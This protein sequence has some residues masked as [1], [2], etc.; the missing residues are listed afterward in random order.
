MC[1]VAAIPVALQWIMAGVTVASGVMAAD[2]QRQEGKIEAAVAE[3]NQRIAV[4]QADESNALA[5]R[6]MEQAAWR[7]RAMMGQQRAAFAA[8]NVDPT[9]GTPADIL[10][11]TAMFGEVDQQNVRLNAA[12]QAWGY[13]SDALN[14]GN[15]ASFARWKGNTQS[16]V[17]I[18]GALG[19]AGQQAA[20]AWGGGG[21]ATKFSKAGPTWS[22]GKTG[23][24]IKAGF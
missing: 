5:T 7:T 4:A 6:E 3:N 12:R 23:G 18:L 2:A 19:Q 13:Q 16:K 10:G 14:Y 17:T 24:N 9:M 1:A 20:G 8:N 22:A 15:Q 21:G 11:E